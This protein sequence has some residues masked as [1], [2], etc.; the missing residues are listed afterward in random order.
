AG[1][2]VPA[3]RVR[4]GHGRLAGRAETGAGL[5]GHAADPPAAVRR[6]GGRGDGDPGRAD[7]PAGPGPRTARGRTPLVAATNAEGLVDR[8]V[9]SS[10]P[11]PGSQAVSQS[12]PQPGPQPARA[13]RVG[14]G[15][16]DPAMLVRSLPDAARK[17]DPRTLWRNPVMFIVEI[18]AVWST[19]LAVRDPSWFGWLIVAWLWLT[20][21]FAN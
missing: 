15:L 5:R 8:P 9:P 17:L 14:A 20:V 18:G 3:D 21:L 4:A 7:V 11:Q 12:G 19:V 1:R 16:L 10:G 13:N 2:P 6:H